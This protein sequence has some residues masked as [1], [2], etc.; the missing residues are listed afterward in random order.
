MVL[1]SGL[2]PP[3]PPAAGAPVKAAG[4]RFSA[5]ERAEGVSAR[6]R[7]ADMGM[8]ERTVAGSRGNDRVAPKPAIL[9]STMEPQGST[10]TGPSTRRA[11]RWRVSE[12]SLSWV[13]Q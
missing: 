3:G 4:Q 2:T 7:G 10:Y 8:M 6:G 9:L 12:T 1:A 11:Q 5:F 13:A